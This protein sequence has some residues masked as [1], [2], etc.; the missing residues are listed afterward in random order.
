MDFEIIMQKKKFHLISRS[1]WELIKN[2]KKKIIRDPKI[3][4][5]RKNRVGSHRISNPDSKTN[6][7]DKSQNNRN[8]RIHNT[9][10]ADL[11]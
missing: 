5:N 11:S 2:L 8:L 6:F 9:E 4:K 1:G 10:N 7:K 3:S